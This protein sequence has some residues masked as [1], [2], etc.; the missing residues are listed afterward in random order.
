MLGAGRTEPGRLAPNDADFALGE[1]V[2]HRLGQF[3]EQ[4]S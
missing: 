3:L 4:W 1:A 2:G